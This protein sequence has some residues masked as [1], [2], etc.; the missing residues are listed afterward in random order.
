MATLSLIDKLRQLTRGRVLMEPEE[1]QPYTRDM[2]I[3][4]MMP[5][6]VVMPERGEEALR[7]L[8]FATA[9]GLSVTPRGGGSGTAGAAL[10]EGLVVVL[11]DAGDW[12]QLDG[13]V[14]DGTGARLDV[15]ASVRHSK[16]QAL[17][18]E[19]GVF[20]PAD[21]SSA[22]ISCI[23][24]NIATRASGPHAL[25]YGAIDR[26]LERVQFITAAGETVDSGDLSTVP[27]RLVRGLADLC[28][29]LRADRPALK[30]LKARAGLKSASG[31]DLAA[32]AEGLPL[33]RL[34]PRLLAGSVGTLG[35]VTGATLRAEPLER[36]RMAVLLAFEHLADAG[37]AVMA[38]Q[39]L[40]ASAIE[41]VSRETVR[42]LRQGTELPATMGA[43][44]HLLLVELSGEEGQGQI[45]RISD[46]LAAAGCRPIQ[47]PS[48]ADGEEEIKA[49][50]GVRS[51]ILWMI[52]N[53]SPG[54]RALA[55]VNDV[56]VPPAQL[57]GFITDV[58]QI[59]DEHAV[60]ALI[61][62]H[63]G[64][65]NLH[66]RPLFDVTTPGLNDR[67]RRLADEVYGAVFRY[68]GTATAEH[69]MGPLRAPYLRQEWGDSLYGYM[70]ELKELFDPQGSL[71][72]G[73][74]FTERS[75]TDRMQPF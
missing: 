31:Y 19:Q 73:A 52:R 51:R 55:V 35:L 4:Q 63:A 75:L 39:P 66:L 7:L 15:G 30:R 18:R 9:E 41:I 22:G 21:V 3:Y 29:R 74:L 34:L 57:A 5:Q 64:D 45:A 69:G 8:E 65:G 24:G 11:P 28:A 72:P 38:L 27:E 47:P 56:G 40:N 16:V 49:L 14:A 33:E 26:F 32:L 36:D 20:L 58:Q 46:V 53:P 61:Y 48:V 23:G 70:K 60:E 12:A 43:D 2:S 13:F 25:R 50:W 62:G 6:A 68:G 59:F 1:V 37:R 10:G 67:I 71:N 54:Y 44:A 42:T 17:L